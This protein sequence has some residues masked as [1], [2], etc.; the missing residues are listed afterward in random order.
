MLA[1]GTHSTSLCTCH[2]ISELTG[3]QA[4]CGDCAAP[5]A[6]VVRV[7]GAAVPRWGRFIVWSLTMMRFW[8]SVSPCMPRSGACPQNGNATMLFHVYFLSGWWC[9]I[10]NLQ[11]AS[12]RASGPFRK[13]TLEG[14]VAPEAE[15]R[16]RWKLCFFPKSLL[17]AERDGCAYL[18]L[19][20]AAAQWNWNCPALLLRSGPVK[21]RIPQF[22]LKPPRLLAPRREGQ[23]MPR[24][25]LWCRH[26]PSEEGPEFPPR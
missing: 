5:C 15:T 14:P 24:P 12:A 4:A 2:A 19:A 8:N 26:R 21:C 1:K 11:A 17:F 3:P 10:L 22:K 20:T 23:N 13:A 7:G 16:L 18:V 6:A 25:L 9:V